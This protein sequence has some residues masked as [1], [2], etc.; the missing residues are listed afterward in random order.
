MRVVLLD[1]AGDAAKARAWVEKSAPG[2]DLLT[3]DKA[4]LKGGSKREALA[5][6]RAEGPWER[7]AIFCNRLDLQPAR[8]LMLLFG[9]MA[10]LLSGDSGIYS[11]Q[12][13][14]PAVVPPA[15][16]RE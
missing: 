8:A 15:Q 6:L 13:V 1:L 9:V 12:R 10:Y 4:E 14:E 16:R 7:F 3:L 5:R 11:G 2:A